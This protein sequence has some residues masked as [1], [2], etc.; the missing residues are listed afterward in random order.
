[1]TPQALYDWVLS[2]SDRT[3]AQA[4]ELEIELAYRGYAKA[5][6]VLQDRPYLP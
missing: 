3:A 2:Q 6:A 5:I 1:M 4:R